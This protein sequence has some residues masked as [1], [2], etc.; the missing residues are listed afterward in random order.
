MICA[1]GLIGAICAAH[2]RAR[3]PCQGRPTIHRKDVT[4]SPRRGQSGH[5]PSHPHRYGTEL[6]PRRHEDGVWH[7]FERRLRR[8]CANRYSRRGCL[9]QVRRGGV[10]AP[11]ES[12][13]AQPIGAPVHMPGNPG[14]WSL[15]GVVPASPAPASSR[16]VLAT[17]SPTIVQDLATVAGRHAAAETV[18]G[19][20]DPVRGLEGAFHRGLSR[21]FRGPYICAAH[22]ALRTILQERGR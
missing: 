4:L 17:A 11:A 3:R 5:N 6:V 8:L 19:L 16:Q 20:A 2:E 15:L 18:A 7:D 12:D 1:S 13:R 22:L 10:C 9:R 14:V 21:A